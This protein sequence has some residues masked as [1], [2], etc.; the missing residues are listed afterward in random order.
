MNR[1]LLTLSGL[2]GE[3]K[4]SFVITNKRKDPRV[5]GTLNLVSRFS[6]WEDRDYC[7][8]RPGGLFCGE[9]PPYGR[10]E[11]WVK[12]V[13]LDV[14][15]P[16]VLPVPRCKVCGVLSSSQGRRVTGAKEGGE[17]L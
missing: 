14:G 12:G 3:T 5:S 4:S 10:P 2:K 6:V 15:V 8:E 13:F 11:E 7:R 16:D 9:C 1:K 17:D